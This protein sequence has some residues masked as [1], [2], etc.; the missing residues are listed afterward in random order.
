MGIPI[1]GLRERTLIL[2]WAVVREKIQ[3]GQCLVDTKSPY[4]P[5]PNLKTSKK[6]TSARPIKKAAVFT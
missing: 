5:L 2:G 4:S 3:E 6:L 1:A